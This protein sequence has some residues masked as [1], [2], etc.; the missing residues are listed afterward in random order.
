MLLPSPPHIPMTAFSNW[1]SSCAATAGTG[2]SSTVL[3][4]PACNFLLSAWTPWIM[5]A[6]CLYTI[7]NQSYTGGCPVNHHVC[8]YGPHKHFS[9]VFSHQLEWEPNSLT[10][11]HKGDV[12]SKRLAEDTPRWPSKDH[13]PTDLLEHRSFAPPCNSICDFLPPSMICNLKGIKTPLLPLHPGHVCLHIPKED[14]ETPLLLLPLNI[15]VLTFLLLLPDGERVH[16]LPS[17][18]LCFLHHKQG[19]WLTSLVRMSEVSLA[20]EIIYYDNR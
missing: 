10:A 4:E 7:N 19:F 9:I 13:L 11:V 14:Y 18:L 16:I 20:T 6:G 1:L 5:R 3:E 8:M 15:P 12:G 2:G 17:K